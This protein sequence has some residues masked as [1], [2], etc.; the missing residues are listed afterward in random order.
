M[1]QNEELVGPKS[2]VA[3]Q[4]QAYEQEL[5]SV[6]LG[7]S[8][9]RERFDLMLWLHD[10]AVCKARHPNA[11]EDA[12]NEALE[13]KREELTSFAGKDTL[14]PAVFEI[15]EIEAP[16]LPPGDVHERIA[17]AGGGAL[18]LRGGETAV[19]VD[20]ETGEEESVPAGTKLLLA[21]EHELYRIAEA[22]IRI[23]DDG[24]RIESDPYP[25]EKI[26]DSK[27]TTSSCKNETPPAT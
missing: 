1:P 26:F 4:A 21:R 17:S 19:R 18:R 5:M 7:V 23:T 16:D 6:L 20:P 3:T 2:A 10:G 25:Q 27:P 22:H 24:Y 11:V 8:E 15:E 9:D 13:A 14:I 12:V